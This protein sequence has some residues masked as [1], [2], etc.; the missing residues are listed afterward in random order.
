M[1]PLFYFVDITVSFSQASYSVSEGDGLAQPVLILSKP[2]RCCNFHVRINVRD[3]TAEST[4][5]YYMHKIVCE[6][7]IHDRHMNNLG[8]VLITCHL[9]R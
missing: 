8:L 6:Y 9:K 2:L 7:T 5:Y 1:L 4:Y 3:I